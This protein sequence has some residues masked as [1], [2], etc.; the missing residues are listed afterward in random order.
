M[1][2]I[3]DHQQTV[4]DIPP[5]DPY[6]DELT[7]ETDQPVR[8]MLLL[9]SCLDWLWQDRNDFF[10]SGNLTIYFNPKQIK[11]QDFRGPD[12]F[13]VLDTERRIRKSWVVW[14]EDGKYPNV[15]VEILSDGMAKTDRETKKEIYQNTFRTPEYFWFDPNTLEFK[16]FLLMGGR[17][18]P[19]EPNATGQCW[20]RQ[21][22]LFLGVE[23]RSLR[24]F[25]PDG[26]LVPTPAEAATQAQR[27]AQQAQQAAQQAQQDM[28]QAQHD[29]Q[30]AQQDVQ[31][32]QQKA[33]RLAARLRKLGVDPDT[34]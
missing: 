32:A 12:F 10:A 3:P 18:E 19:I 24:F 20:S 21:L 6:S 17:Y 4:I 9:T 7:M 15:I 22:E 33:Q 23:G 28:Q 11:S 1:I 25:T 5:G 16:G 13:V 34:L 2:A 8:Q 27:V 29:V 26:T 30:Q 14:E 31:Q